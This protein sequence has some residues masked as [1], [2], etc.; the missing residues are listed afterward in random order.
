MNTEKYS[1][2]FTTGALFHQESVNLAGWYLEKG[3]W[4]AV[5]DEVVAK[6][7]IQARTTNSTKRICREICSR[8]KRLNKEELELL[9]DG[10]HQEQAY[11]LWL[12]VCRR[13]H[14]IYDFST[15]VIRERFLTLRYDLGYEDFDAFFN[16]KMEWHEEM[17][18]ITA[19]TRNKLRQ[20][21]FRMLRESELLNSDNSIIPA[22][23]SARLINVICSHSNRD[24]HLFPIMEVALQ[25]CAE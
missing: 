15:E 8:L 19:T 1:M 10:D 2:S 24:L 21:V 7:L 12:A 4:N 18:K 6:N 9:V 20:V 22:M 14:F 17:E 25:G 3:N 13:Y 11:I 5:R 16:A 23:L